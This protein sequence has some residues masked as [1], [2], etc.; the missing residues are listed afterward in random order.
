MRN[1]EKFADKRV[2]VVGMA[3]SGV[4]AA[5]LLHRAGAKVVINDSK[6]AEVLGDALAPLAGL[7]IEYALGCP[8]GAVSYTHLRAHET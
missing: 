6:T 5:R 3:R 2:L 7:D 1:I 8:A 4:A